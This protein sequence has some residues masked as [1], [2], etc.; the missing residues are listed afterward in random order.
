MTE[1]IQILQY[2]LECISKDPKRIL[3][4]LSNVFRRKRS[5]AAPDKRRMHVWPELFS[6]FWAFGSYRILHP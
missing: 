3:D 4:S 1:Q 2:R 5:F 6:L